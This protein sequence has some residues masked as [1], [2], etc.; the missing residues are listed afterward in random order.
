MAFWVHADEGGTPKEIRLIFESLSELVGVIERLNTEFAPPRPLAFGAGL[1]SGMAVTG[2]MG[3][4]AVSDHTAMG[5]A[6]NKAFRLE[7]A[8]K[9]V[10][11]EIVIGRSTYDL[12]RARDD[13][14]DA[15]SKH[16]VHLKG[17]DAPEE[18]LAL[19][20]DDLARVTEALG[21]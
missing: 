20:L 21:S 3:S 4:A 12:I 8:S 19:G 10:G 15:F 9:E 16:T 14:A 6:V 13:V 17:Y 5:D 2:N 1:N 11:R 7:T 18:V